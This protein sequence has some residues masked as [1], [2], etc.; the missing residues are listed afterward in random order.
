MVRQPTCSDADKSS[1]E[2]RV[3]SET[4]KEA[5]TAT[6][7]LESYLTPSKGPGRVAQVGV[8]EPDMHEAMVAAVKSQKDVM[9]DLMVKFMDP[10]KSWRLMNQTWWVISQQ[11]DRQLIR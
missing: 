7:E 10:S 5:V 8:E 3:A 11:I 6:L 4:I 9:L 1:S 2:Y